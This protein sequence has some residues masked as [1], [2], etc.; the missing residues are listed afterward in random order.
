MDTV[1]SVQST[2]R[3]C[4]IDFSRHFSDNPF[5]GTG[6][7]ISEK[8]PCLKKVDAQLYME[9]DMRLMFVVKSFILT[10]YIFQSPSYPLNQHS[11]V[12]QMI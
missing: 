8:S 4:M 11:F 5:R 1:L 3:L 6:N 2:S 12:S 7:P 10:L 9:L